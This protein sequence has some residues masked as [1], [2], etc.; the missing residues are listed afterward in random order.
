M[1]KQDHRPGGGVAVA[2]T[3]DWGEPTPSTQNLADKRALGY[4][5][6]EAEGEVGRILGEARVVFKRLCDA[7]RKTG[8]M[9][10][11]YGEWWRVYVS[12]K[13]FEKLFWAY[14][15]EVSIYRIRSIMSESEVLGGEVDRWE[16]DGERMLASWKAHGVPAND[17]LALARYRR[18][19]DRRGENLRNYRGG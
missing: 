10:L 6:E 13:G 5:R 9:E 1:L 12:G 2:A 4:G 8:D 16:E 15:R 19:H 17:F 18:E 3:P 14:W 11:I 7:E